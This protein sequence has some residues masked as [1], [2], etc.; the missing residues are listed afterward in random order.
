MI[1]KLNSTKNNFF[2]VVCD[3]FSEG[4]IYKDSGG[5]HTKRGAQKHSLK[6][7]EKMGEGLFSFLKESKEEKFDVMVKNHRYREQNKLNTHMKYFIKNWNKDYP[8]NS[9]YMDKKIY[10]TKVRFKSKRRV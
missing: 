10:K 8:Y 6:V 1:I 4:V 9:L 3:N 2:I 7:I 5:R